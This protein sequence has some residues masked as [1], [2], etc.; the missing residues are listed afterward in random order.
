MKYAR[1]TK[2]E[3]NVGHGDILGFVELTSTASI[4]LRK[5]SQ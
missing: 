3:S 2:E 4:D 1:S 5:S